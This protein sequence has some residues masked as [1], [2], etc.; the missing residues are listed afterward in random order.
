MITK[1]RTTVQ[2]HEREYIHSVACDI[3]QKTRTASGVE[4]VDPNSWAG[5]FQVNT[6]TIEREFGE[7]YPESRNVVTKTCDI[8]P[9]C[10]ETV[11]VPFLESKGVKMREERS[12]W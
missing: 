2:A 3:C 11:L 10:F 5:G 12:E 7:S 9:T 4:D 6:T 8:C 1:G